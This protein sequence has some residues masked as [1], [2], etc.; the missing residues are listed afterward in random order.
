MASPASFQ[1][2][3]PAVPCR[4]LNMNGWGDK[5][6]VGVVSR[7]T[8]QKGEPGEGRTPACLHT[9][10]SQGW[11]ICAACHSCCLPRP[12]WLARPAAGTHLIKHSCYRTLDR[13]GQ[14]VLLGSAPDPKIQAEF[15]AL[16]SQVGGWVLRYRG[17]SGCG[18]TG[19]QGAGCVGIRA[20]A[21]NWQ[22]GSGCR[23]PWA[24]A[25][26]CMQ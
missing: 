26:T 9:A 18:A 4:R 14:F 13:G 25:T 8:K 20:A 7:L 2:H 5:P 22:L 11:P 3:M 1:P 17:C 12:P 24:A 23:L 19:W 15:A 6:L 16:Q 10:C 21:L